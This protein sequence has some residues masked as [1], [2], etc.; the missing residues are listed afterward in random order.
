[1]PQKVLESRNK[2]IIACKMTTAIYQNR[3]RQTPSKILKIIGKYFARFVA[4]ETLSA[5][6]DHC[7]AMKW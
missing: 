2:S 6:N 3:R 1:M 5:S 4:I 7:R